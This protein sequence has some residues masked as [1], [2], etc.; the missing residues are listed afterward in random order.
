MIFGPTAASFAAAMMTEMFKP[1]A[2]GSED[3][4]QL[5]EPA[6]MSDP[7]MQVEKSASPEPPTFDPQAGVFCH[8]P[9]QAEKSAE[10]P[11]INPRAG[12]FWPMQVEESA[13]LEPPTND[14]QTG[15]LS[16]LADI[17]NHIRQQKE[18]VADFL[19]DARETYQF[20]TNLLAIKMAKVNF[21]SE[22][23]DE[24]SN[25]LRDLASLNRAPRVGSLSYG[26]S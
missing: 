20:L 2:S 15:E 5:G 7:P 9:M 18:M 8:P 1:A 26:V 24:M 25:A 14:P 17:P 13:S 19:R 11:T 6:P 16:R 4:P 3:F 23:L 12:R 21:G 10:P 22:E